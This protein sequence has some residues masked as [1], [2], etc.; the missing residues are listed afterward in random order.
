M[1]AGLAVA[2]KVLAY[3]NPPLRTLRTLSLTW[4]WCPRGKIK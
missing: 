2:E 3:K 1:Q 4:T